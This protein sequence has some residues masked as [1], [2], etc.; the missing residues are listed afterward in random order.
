[1]VNNSIII[2]KWKQSP[3]T[4]VN[5]CPGLGQAQQCGE[6]NPINGIPTLLLLIIGSLT[7]CI[8]KQTITVS[9]RFHSKELHH[10]VI[11]KHITA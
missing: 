7:Q 8:Y 11:L 10:T 1:M 5:S 4:L 2:N 9:I 6:V 3:L